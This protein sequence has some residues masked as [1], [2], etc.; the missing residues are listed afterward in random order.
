[1]AHCHLAA[2]LRQ[3]S[4]IHLLKKLFTLKLKLAVL[5]KA[6]ASPVHP[7]A[8]HAEGNPLEHPKIFHAAPIEYCAVTG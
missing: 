8:H 5:E 3:Q 2:G 7:N 4:F 6:W 1:M